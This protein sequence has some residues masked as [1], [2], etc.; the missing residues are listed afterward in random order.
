MTILYH[1]KISQA[2]KGKKIS[3]PKIFLIKKIKNKIDE[4]KKEE[5]ETDLEE[6]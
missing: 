1:Q 5:D 3:K 2:K 4:L 6:Q